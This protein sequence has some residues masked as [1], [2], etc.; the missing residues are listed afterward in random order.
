MEHGKHKM[1]DGKIMS[2]KEMKKKMG[3]HKTGGKYMLHQKVA[4]GEKVK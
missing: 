4:R 1:P 2:D 3:T